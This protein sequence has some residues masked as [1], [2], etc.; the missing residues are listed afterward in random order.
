MSSSGVLRIGQKTFP[1]VSM[2]IFHATRMDIS[3]KPTN[4]VRTTLNMCIESFR[5]DENFWK[6]MR[7]HPTRFDGEITYMPSESSSEV[8]NYLIRSAGLNF[9][10]NYHL[11]AESFPMKLEVLIHTDEKLIEKKTNM[12]GLLNDLMR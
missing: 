1:I 3:G 10:K 9:K 2:D 4:H 11:E 12:D 5:G 8:S 7:Y 6:K